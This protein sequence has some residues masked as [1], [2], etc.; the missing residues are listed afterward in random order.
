MFAKKN[1]TSQTKVKRKMNVKTTDSGFGR[2]RFACYV[3]F[4]IQAI[5]INFPP[6][7]FLQFSNSYDIPLAKITLLVTINF[8]CQ[9]CID[10]LSA[11]FA[12]HLSYRVMVIASNVFCAMGLVMYGTLPDLLPDSYLGLIIATLFSAIGSGLIEVIANPLMQSCPK[13]K[14]DFSMGF[15]HSFYCWGALGVVLLSTLALLA[16]GMGNWRILAFIWATV[17]TANAILFCFSPINQPSKELEETSSLKKLV[18]TST[19]W[20]FIFIMILGGACEQG[21]AQ[22]A[23]AYAELALVNVVSGEHAKLLGDLLGP[24]FFALTMAASRMLYPKVCEKF[25]LRKT[26]IISSILC[27]GC[28]TLAAI[29]KNPYLSLIGCGVCGFSVGI[30]WPGT[31]DLAGKTCAFVGTAL[32]AMLSLAGDLGCLLG[33]TLVGLTADT[34]GGDL[35]IGMAAAISLPVILTVILLLFRSKP[36][37]NQKTK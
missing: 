4:I 2:T 14:K 12:K 36:K 17:P 22:W 35:K 33:P 23:S 7:L 27:A 20:L 18:K 25:D 21:M 3:C 26:M 32:F 1:K 16:T 15:L 13:P 24:C 19:F 37:K 8:A 9:F 34:F 30:M 11:I 6:I 28:Y 29:T 31:L 10:M 5:I